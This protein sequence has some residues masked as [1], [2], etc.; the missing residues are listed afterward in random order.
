VSIRSPHPRRE[1]VVK[2]AGAPVARFYRVELDGFD[3]VTLRL[4]EAPLADLV[5]QDGRLVG[6]AVE[7][8]TRAVLV[9]ADASGGLRGRAVDPI[10]LRA[11][12][13]CFD[14]SQGGIRTRENRRARGAFNALVQEA[15]AFGMVN[16]YVHTD[17]AVGR[18]DR[19]LA[20]LGAPPLPRIGVVVGAHFGSKLPGFAHGE[21]DMR[22]GTLRPLSGGHYRLSTRTTG[23]PEPVPVAPTGEIHLGPSRYRKPFAGF[24]SYLR[25]AA[26]NPAIVYHEAGHHLCRHTADFRANAGRRPDRQRNGKT[27]VEEGVCDYFAAAL[28]G[29][30][31]PYGWYRADRGRR[32]DLELRRHAS[33]V[34]DGSDAHALGATWA[35]AWWRC[36]GIL[37][38][39]GTLRS[40][41][42][43]DRILVHALL[44]VGEV[45]TNGSSRRR[46]EA[47]RSRAETMLGEYVVAV[48]DAAGA[49]AAGSVQAVLEESGLVETAALAPEVT[50]SC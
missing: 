1:P 8:G 18:F 3:D 16:A 7:V 24:T 25:N 21:G 5:V 28:L 37:T 46:R 15:N 44:R 6:P 42:D 9:E 48:T 36:R 26:H 50:A 10:E 49:R 11:G 35:A 22:T 32:R 40:P 33:H 47:R 14:P 12:A 39:D 43:H 30:G 34:V 13:L 23:V 17:R 20:E 4:D 29:S 41:A 45:G 31:R 27:G 19:M 38:A 2:Q